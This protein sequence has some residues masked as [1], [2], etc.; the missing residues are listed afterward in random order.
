MADFI[1]ARSDEQKEQRLAE[2]KRATSELFEGHPY[3]E[4]TLTTIAD[5]LGWSRANLW[6]S[7]ARR[8]RAIAARG[9]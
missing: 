6:R 9:T 5:R 1:R 2:I 3:H 8:R 7:H 4:I